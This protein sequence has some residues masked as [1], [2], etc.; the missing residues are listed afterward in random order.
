L[1]DL[2]GLLKGAKCDS[3]VAVGFQDGEKNEN[4][5]LAS[6][7]QITDA[8]NLIFRWIQTVDVEHDGHVWQSLVYAIVLVHFATKDAAIKNIQS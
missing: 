2:N 1:F 5:V 8:K 4:C 6:A 7:N 3:V